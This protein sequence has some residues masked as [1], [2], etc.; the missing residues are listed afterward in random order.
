M[1]RYL[2]LHKRLK[3][4][5]KRSPWSDNI[6]FGNIKHTT[7]S[8]STSTLFQELIIEDLDSSEYPLLRQEDDVF[9]D[10]VSDVNNDDETFLDSND[11]DNFLELPSPKRK[12]TPKKP[13]V[14][15]RSKREK[16]NNRNFKEEDWI[17][18]SHIT[19]SKD[20]LKPTV[21]IVSNEIKYD[22]I[23]FKFAKKFD[24]KFYTG[25]VTQIGEG[26]VKE[27]VYNDRDEENLPLLQIR[28]LKKTSNMLKI[29]PSTIRFHVVK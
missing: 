27:I 13:P 28:A 20:I 12:S 14:I 29:L 15:R 23:G 1:V 17:L 3:N 24:S 5:I 22:N 7:I 4:T 2:W 18:S 9:F 10:S 19:N 16:I 8:T 6:R 25:T 26:N 21:D 11:D